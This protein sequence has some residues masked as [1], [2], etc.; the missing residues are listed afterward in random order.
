MN[1][2]LMDVCYLIEEPEENTNLYFCLFDASQIVFLSCSST[3]SKFVS[4][5]LTHLVMLAFYDSEYN[6]SPFGYILLC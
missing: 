3:V 1:T 6:V 4:L 2:C 5:R